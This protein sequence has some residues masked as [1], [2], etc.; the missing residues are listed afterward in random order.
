VRTGF[1]YLSVNARLLDDVDVFTLQVRRYDGRTEMP[2]G[3]VPPLHD[4]DSA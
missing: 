2:G 1:N 4:P 3:D